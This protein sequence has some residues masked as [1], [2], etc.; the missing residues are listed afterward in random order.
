MIGCATLAVASVALGQVTAL[1]AVDGGVRLATTPVLRSDG[2]PASVRVLV[3]GQF[4][5]F[6]AQRPCRARRDAHPS[7]R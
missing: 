4:R 7:A 6:A 2:D 1:E 3:D 5:R